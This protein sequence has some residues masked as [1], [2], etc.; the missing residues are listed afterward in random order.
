[1]ERK[2][3]LIVLVFCLSLCIPVGHYTGVPDISI[4]LYNVQIGDYELPI[5]LS[6]HLASVKPT[7]APGILGAGWS[8]KAGGYIARSVRGRTDEKRRIPFSDR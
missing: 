5:S 4:P 6:Y 8:L 3:G 1:M 7:T 2:I